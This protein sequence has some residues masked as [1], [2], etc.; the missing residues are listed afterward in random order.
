MLGSGKRVLVYH[1]LPVRCRECGAPM[2]LRLTQDGKKAL[3]KAVEVS[4]F[5]DE[6]VLQ[7]YQCARK[8]PDGNLCNGLVEIRVKHI[9]RVPS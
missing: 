3:E 6:V 8:L 4:Q 2:R 7:T 9:K 1:P 5:G